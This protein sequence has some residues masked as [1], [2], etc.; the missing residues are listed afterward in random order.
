VTDKERLIEITD[1]DEITKLHV[2]V[3]LG[4][5]HCFSSRDKTGIHFWANAEDLRAWRALQTTGEQT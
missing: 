2:N 3:D 5:P 1:P 4:R